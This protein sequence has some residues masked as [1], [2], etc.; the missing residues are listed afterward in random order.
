MPYN[1]ST[2]YFQRHISLVFPCSLELC[3]EPFRSSYPFRFLNRI[4][5][6]CKWSAMTE[7]AYR[8]IENNFRRKSNYK[9]LIVRDATCAKQ[10]TPQF[11]C[12][13]CTR[14]LSIS[15][16]RVSLLCSF[17]FHRV[18]DRT[19]KEQKVSDIFFPR[20]WFRFFLLFLQTRVSLSLARVG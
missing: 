19:R 13:P 6:T 8:W 15:L 14:F 9:R 12:S 10:T 3:N 16:Q 4:T 1:P 7:R 2:T 18:D 11:V 20:L 5:R 17:F